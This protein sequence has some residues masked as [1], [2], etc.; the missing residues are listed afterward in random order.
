M[1]R[2]AWFA[3]AVALLFASRPASAQQ[4]HDENGQS[5]LISEGAEKCAVKHFKQRTKLT[6][7]VLQDWK[8]DFTGAK[9]KADS[10]CQKVKAGLLEAFD[11]AENAVDGE[12]MEIYFAL[13]K[14]NDAYWT[15]S[16]WDSLNYNTENLIVVN[17]TLDDAGKWV[18]F[19]HEGAH[20]AGYTHSGSF[21]AYDAEDCATEGE[22]DPGGGGSNENDPDPDDPTCTTTTEWVHGGWRYCGSNWSGGDLPDLTV[23]VEEI[24]IPVEVTI[25][26]S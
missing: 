13:R 18:T 17:D 25:C 8:N 2:A 26:E 11:M 14:D 22:D 10:N 24:Y 23:C 9:W 12:I 3:L 20:H 4:A 15:G 1:R 21:T 16:Y 5:C 6:G 19:L 7:K